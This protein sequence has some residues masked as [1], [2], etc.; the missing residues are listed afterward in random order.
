MIKWLI[1]FPPLVQFIFFL[2]LFRVYS[3]VRTL[4]PVIPEISL[5]DRLKESRALTFSSTG[6]RLGYFFTNFSVMVRG[7]EIMFADF[8]MLYNLGIL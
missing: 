5:L 4:L 8:D 7:I 3:M 2:M 6:L 1:R